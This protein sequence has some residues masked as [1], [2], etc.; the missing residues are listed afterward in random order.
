MGGRREWEGGQIF[1]DGQLVDY[2]CD[3]DWG[4]WGELG[5]LSFDYAFHCCQSWGQSDLW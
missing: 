4:Y 2:R 1:I 3:T 5:F